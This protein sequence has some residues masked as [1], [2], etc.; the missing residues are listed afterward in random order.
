VLAALAMLAACSSSGSDTRS[1]ATAGDRRPA[2]GFDLEGVR[3]SDS[4]V[5]LADLAGRPVVVNFF[6]SW[7]DPCKRE[8]PA[9][10]AVHREVGDRISF[11]GIDNTDSRRNA[12]ALLRR[13]GVSY[14]AGYDPTGDV[15]SDYRLLG[16]PTTVFLD[17][18]GVEVERHTGPL[19]R[20]ELR[21]LLDR[22]FPEG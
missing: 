17:E 16:M 15:A 1:E 11:V 18:R 13:T 9:F 21:E 10:A 6:A 8:L 2:P 5:R 4:R 20:D 3:P 22:L 19:E 12:V 14:P 7:C